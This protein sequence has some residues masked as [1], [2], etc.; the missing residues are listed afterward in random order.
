MNYKGTV[1]MP[2][3]PVAI[4]EVGRGQEEKIKETIE[5][6]YRGAKEI[7]S[8]K[9]DILV[10]V[11]PHGN[12][13]KDA[14]SIIDVEELTGSLTQFG[15]R[16]K[17]K[18]KVFQDIKKE[19]QVE[20]LKKGTPHVFIGELEAKQYRLK[21]ELDHG[22]LVPLYYIDKEYLDYEVIH[23]TP[24]FINALDLYSA[25]SI[26]SQVMENIDKTYAVI[27]SA[28]LSHCLKD[29]GPYEYHPDGVEFDR[30]V[31]QY[32]SENKPEKIFSIPKKTIKNAG[33]CGYNSYA[34]ALGISDAY[35]TEIEIF[36]YEGSFGVGYL[37]AVERIIGVSKHPRLDKI[38]NEIKANYHE[39]V[40][41][42]DAYVQLARKVIEQHIKEKKRIKWA[43]M[44]EG[45]DDQFIKEVTSIS[46]GAFVTIEKDGELRG[47]IGTTEPTKD[48]LAE[49]I[50]ANAISAATRDPR[51]PKINEKELEHLEVKVDVLGELEKIDSKDQ[52]DIKKYGVV[53]KKGVRKGLLLPDLDGVKDINHQIEIARQKAGLLDYEKYE[54]YRFKVKRHF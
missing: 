33:Q 45:F 23:I 46:R 13:F 17:F 11:S 40:K 36:S 29:S 2:H 44:K 20:W 14:L 43:D 10:I 19:L 32:F 35:Q 48:C 7:A 47:C 49:E 42:E 22:A 28:D 9:P 26:F 4:P 18:K 8:W 25:G 37:N 50:I 1:Y 39:R 6:F 41:S 16:E 24:G 34:F 52:L 51:F 30:L 15:Y 54:L 38:N 3:P 53:V 21:L 5:G 31:R 27:A 12:S